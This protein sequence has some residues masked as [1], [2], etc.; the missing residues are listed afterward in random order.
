MNFILLP[1]GSGGF[2]V[3]GLLSRLFPPR[4]DALDRSGLKDALE[5]QYRITRKGIERNPYV[6]A[7][8]RI[9]SVREG[10]RYRGCRF[11]EM[12]A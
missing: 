6:F 8:V 10:Y 3:E 5:Y 7:G 2:S 9:V 4:M 1:A 12:V 11:R